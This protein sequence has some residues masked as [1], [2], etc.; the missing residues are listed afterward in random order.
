[1]KATYN[2]KLQPGTEWRGCAAS[3]GGA[4]V[5]AKEVTKGV[6]NLFNPKGE[7]VI[8]SAREGVEIGQVTIVAEPKK[9]K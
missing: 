6:F 4:I 7:L 2:L 3:D 8:G 1:M 5:E 9:E